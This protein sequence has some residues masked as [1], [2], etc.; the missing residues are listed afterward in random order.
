MCVLVC[1]RVS[2]CVKKKKEEKKEKK[3]CLAT[4]G[5]ERVKLIEEND[6]RHCLPCSLEHL[7]SGLV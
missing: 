7:C 3:E 4:V 6:A 5:C 1:V 2:V